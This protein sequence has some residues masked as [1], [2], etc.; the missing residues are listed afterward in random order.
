[1]KTKSVHIRVTE[2]QLSFINDERF[3]NKSEVVRKSIDL[4]MRKVAEVDQLKSIAKAKK[5]RGA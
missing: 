1:M 5:E 2:D 3:G 4:F